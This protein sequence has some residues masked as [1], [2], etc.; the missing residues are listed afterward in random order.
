M[1]GARVDDHPGDHLQTP[2]TDA[3]YFSQTSWH[4][5]CVPERQ[6]TG[7][8]YAFFLPNLGVCAAADNSHDQ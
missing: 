7:Q 8:L 4:T 5:F 3:T 1:T 6:L 2:T